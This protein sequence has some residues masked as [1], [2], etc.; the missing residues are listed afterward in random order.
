MN[1]ANG[2]FKSWRVSLFLRAANRRVYSLDFHREK[3]PAAREFLAQTSRSGCA[4]FHLEGLNGWPRTF[5]TGLV[6]LGPCSH[7]GIVLRLLRT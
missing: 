7:P 3:P 4:C 1:Q 6:R 2:Q 5:G